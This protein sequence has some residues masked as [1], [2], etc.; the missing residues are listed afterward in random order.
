MP[1]L[2]LRTIIKSQTYFA[3]PLCFPLVR[4]SDFF[5]AARALSVLG[6]DAALSVLSFGYWRLRLSELRRGLVCPD[7]RGAPIGAPV[8]EAAHRHKLATKS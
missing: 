3:L 6:F 4:R 1:T 7:L 8:F 5:I 2:E